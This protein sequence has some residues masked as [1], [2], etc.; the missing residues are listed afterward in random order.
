M[1]SLARR[2]GVHH[3]TVS[4]LLRREG[5]A[6]ATT[7]RQL[8]IQLGW[9]VD[10]VETIVAEERVA[11]VLEAVHRPH[12]RAESRWLAS[13]TGIPLDDINILL[14]KLLAEG[15]LLMLSRSHWLVRR[16]ENE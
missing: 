10:R 8:G 16:E 11:A 15:R 5:P 12:F 1:R 7:V 9:P 14:H 3:A 13:R 6:P 2:L 4:R